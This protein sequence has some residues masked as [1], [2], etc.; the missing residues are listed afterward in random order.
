LCFPTVITIFHLLSLIAC[1]DHF[2]QDVEASLRRNLPII[3][4]PHAKEHLANK[5]GDGEAFTAVYDLDAF[6]SMMV[7]IKPGSLGQAQQ[8][9]GGQRGPAIKVT[10]MPGKHV[11]PGILNTLNDLAG[12][13]STPKSDI[14][15]NNHFL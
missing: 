13:V 5:S 11:P 10:A 3:T 12:A 2:D 14:C 9:Q 6:Q 4:T 15:I 7:D 1:S 8:H